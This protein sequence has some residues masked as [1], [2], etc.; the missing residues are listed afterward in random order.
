[1]FLQG[2]FSSPRGKR[3]SFILLVFVFS[4]GEECYH[5]N[6]NDF[7][8]GETHDE[9]L[10]R[11]QCQSQAESTILFIVN[12]FGPRKKGAIFMSPSIL[13]PRRKKVMPAWLIVL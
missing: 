1:M 12:V 8:G 5:K 9:E 6:V 4:P 7:W 2:A 13:R 10:K 11:F 3:T